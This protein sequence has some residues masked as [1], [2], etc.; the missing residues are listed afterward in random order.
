MSRPLITI[1]QLLSMG[2]DYGSSGLAILAASNRTHRP[3][4]TISHCLIMGIDYGSLGS[5]NP[6]SLQCIHT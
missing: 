6:P 3:L 2:S 1:C 4:I 5:L